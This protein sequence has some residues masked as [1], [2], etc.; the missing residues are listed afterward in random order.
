MLTPETGHTIGQ[1][2][3]AGHMPAADT[4]HTD[5]GLA[6]LATLKAAASLGSAVGSGPE[7]S[8]GSLGLGLTEAEGLP[9][10]RLISSAAS[11]LRH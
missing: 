1:L 9:P 2:A 6:V 8:L 11:G 7:G 4:G 5:T 10:A 3:K